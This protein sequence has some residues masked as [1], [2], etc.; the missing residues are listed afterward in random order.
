MLRKQ[1]DFKKHTFLDEYKIQIASCE[2]Q[3]V[4][5]IVSAHEINVRLD[6]T[7]RKINYILDLI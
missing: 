6:I 2:P 7:H 3:L 1:G 5:P 4:A